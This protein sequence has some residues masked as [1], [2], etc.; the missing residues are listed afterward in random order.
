[1]SWL[2][3]AGASTTDQRITELGG[4]I[5]LALALVTVFTAQRWQALRDRREV[6]GKT[7]L[8][9]L[10]GSAIDLS[11]LALTV[12][13]TAAAFPLFRDALEDLSW[14]DSESALRSTFAVIWLLLVGLIVW[15][16]SIAARTV[17]QVR[18]RPWRKRGR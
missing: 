4:L 13:L 6:P 16:V 5:S 17:A 2:A 3:S 14:G 15:Q 12:A 9:V 1:M 11:L 7:K 10:Q 8:R 18:G